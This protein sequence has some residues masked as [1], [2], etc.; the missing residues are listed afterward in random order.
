MNIILIISDTFRQDHLE[1]YGNK[2]IHTPNLDAFAK[3]SIVFHNY[4][5]G[6]Y[7]TLPNRGDLLTGKFSFS[8]LG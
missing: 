4:Y 1:I 7:P 8:Y 3:E 6:S 2:G 5:A